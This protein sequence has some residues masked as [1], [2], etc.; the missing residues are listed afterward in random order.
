[1]ESEPAELDNVEKLG[2]TTGHTKGTITAF[3]VDDVIVEYEIGNLRFN[4]QIE[5]EG[6]GS[7]AF[8]D[9]GDSGSL[10]FTS[11]GQ[12]ALGLLFAGSQQGG[13]NGRGLTYANP[14]ENV[15]SAL[16]AELVT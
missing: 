6:A 8:S 7:R 1:M 12:H 2:R 15:L 9:G 4:N 3:E 16:N 11:A 13:T 10:I 5:I 14:L